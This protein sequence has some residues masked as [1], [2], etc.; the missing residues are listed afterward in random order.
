MTKEQ[1]LVIDSKVKQGYT[2]LGESVSILNGLSVYILIKSRHTLAINSLGYDE[3]FVGK[4]WKI[5]E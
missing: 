3:Q 2:L 4:T 5:K 1:K